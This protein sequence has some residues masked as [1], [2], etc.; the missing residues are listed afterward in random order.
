MSNHYFDVFD[1][2]S[3]LRTCNV[4]VAACGSF[5]DVGFQ[6][7][8]LKNGPERSREANTHV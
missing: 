3:K 7:V 4:S 6:N 8:Q 5:F 1:L 2:F